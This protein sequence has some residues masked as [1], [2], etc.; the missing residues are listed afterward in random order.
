M[1]HRAQRCVRWTILLRTRLDEGQGHGCRVQAHDVA[2]ACAAAIAARR[3]PAM[4][5]GTGH[6]GPRTTEGRRQQTTRPPGPHR[7]HGLAR[8]RAAGAAADRGLASEAA[9]PA[10]H[11]S[12]RASP[13]DGR[14]ARRWRVHGCAPWEPCAV[15]GPCHRM[16]GMA[17]VRMGAPVEP[18]RRSGAPKKANS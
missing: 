6:Q 17:N 10:R 3:P 14:E 18:R 8:Y 12:S 7:P 16:K 9:L 1:G 5:P 13:C 2:R 4:A 11:A 15:C